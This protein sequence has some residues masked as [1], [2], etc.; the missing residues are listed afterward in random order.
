MLDLLE[1]TSIIVSDIENI[2]DKKYLVQALS[3]VDFSEVLPELAIKPK[4]VKDLSYESSGKNLKFNLGYINY[5][6][7]TLWNKKTSI[8]DY[9]LDIL[10]DEIN[11]QKFKKFEKN[12]YNKI[13]IKMSWNKRLIKNN[14][15]IFFFW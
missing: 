2:D 5:E 13:P 8:W 6:I 11:F 7:R 4:L 14:F 3:Y 10:I 12:F 15:W 9:F 1:G